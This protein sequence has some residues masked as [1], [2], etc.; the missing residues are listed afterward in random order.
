MGWKSFLVCSN[1][2]CSVILWNEESAT[3]E[4]DY[5]SILMFLTEFMLATQV[6]VP[7]NDKS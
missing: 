3:D 1:P 4:K 6:F 7:Q 2:E 5:S